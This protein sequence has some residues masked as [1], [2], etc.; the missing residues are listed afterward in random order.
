LIVEIKAESNLTSIDEAQI[1]N[2]LRCGKKKIGL[3][4]NFGEMSLVYRRFIN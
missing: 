2:A 4:I 3:L 1:I